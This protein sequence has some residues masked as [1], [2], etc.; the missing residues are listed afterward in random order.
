MET[1][2][3]TT[4][5]QSRGLS[6]GEV[7]QR[8][9]DFFWRSLLQLVQIFLLHTLCTVSETLALCHTQTVVDEKMD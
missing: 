3:G 4:F 8:N 1:Y 5:P 9:G 6:D 7:G 2:F